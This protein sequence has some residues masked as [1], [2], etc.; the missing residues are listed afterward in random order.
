MIVT[1]IHGNLDAYKT[2]RDEFLRLHAL[3]QAHH[4]VLCGDLI[5][6]YGKPSEDASVP[7]L[8]DVMRLQAELGTQTVIL[9]LG[10]HEF[11]HIYNVILT[12]GGI[13]FTSRFE[14]SLSIAVDEARRQQVIDFLIDLPFYVC[15]RGGV[16]ISHAGASPHVLVTQQ[17]RDLSTFD[18]R[19]LLQRAD[20]DIRTHYDLDRLRDNA[21]YCQQ[22]AQFFAISD[23]QHPR[24]HHYLRGQII[25]QTMPEF[26][27]LWDAFFNQNEREY[28][29][30]THEN[31]VKSFLTAMSSISP[32][33]Q[34]V[35][36]MGHMPVEGG[37]ALITRQLLRLA[38]HAHANPPRDAEYLLLDCAQPIQYAL[39]L[40]PMLRKTQAIK[41]AP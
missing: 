9:L 29:K 41:N 36:V 40:L 32:A 15:T 28:G 12:K 35:L 25:T 5:H 3:N 34:N 30:N 8:L 14:R 18:H 37:H 26:Q 10:N 4:L 17:A 2:L 13:E 19:A 27:H 1:D 21:D 7:I 20:E 24:F 39:E 16:F 31:M 6:G 11:V 22:V 38:S 33:P 23:P